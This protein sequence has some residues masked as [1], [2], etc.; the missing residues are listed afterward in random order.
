MTDGYLALLDALLADGLRALGPAFGALQSEYVQQLQLADGGFP[1]R[2]GG[3]DLYYTDFALRVLTLTTAPPPTL[4]RATEYLS[5]T[6]TEP[7][8]VVECFSWLNSRRLL[9]Q[10]GLEVPLD[11]GNLGIVLSG[12]CLLDGGYSVP[13]GSA[14]N[15]YQTFIAALCLEMLGE[16]FDYV[17]DAVAE[18]ARLQT[19]DGG[20]QNQAGEGRAQTS[21]TAAALGFLTMQEAPTEEQTR[22]A[23]AFLVRMQAGDG[24]LRAHPQARGSDL[25]ST[26]TGFLSLAMLEAHGGLNLQSLGRFVRGCASATGGFGAFPGD[27]G[28]DVEYTYYGVGCVALLGAI[29]QASE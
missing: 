11:S 17:E 7:D 29:A 2:Q 5:Q 24:G 13:Y 28:A 18:I 6:S 25:L 21:A 10:A 22:A 4:A 23:C 16:E 12:Q 1:G 3:S 9:V 8:S 20:F 19:D 15:A 27:D 14:A 26:F